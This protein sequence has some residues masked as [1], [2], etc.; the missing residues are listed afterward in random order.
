VPTMKILFFSSLFYP[1]IGGVE[2]HVME[3]SKLLIEKNHRISVVTENY[4]QELKSKENIKGIEIIRIPRIKKGKLKKFKI[5]KWLFENR[6]IISDADIIHCHDVFFWYMPFM[7]FYIKK[8]VYTTFHGYE[9]Y[10]LKLKDILMHKIAEK[11]SFGNIAVGSFIKKWYG[12][13]PTYITYGGVNKVKSDPPRWAG[14][15][16]I[17]S[18]KGAVFVGRL[19]K[20]TGIKT[21]VN[22]V[23]LIR[24]QMPFFKFG[25]IGDGKLRKEIKKNFKVLGFQRNP[26]KYFS[27]YNFAFASGYLSILE[28]MAEKRLIFADYDNPLKEDYLRMTPFSKFIV[29]SNSSS[30]LVSKIIFY[31]NNT[32]KQEQITEDA[33]EWVRKHTWKDVV[34]IYLK[35]W[36]L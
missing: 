14:K 17:K 16:K 26:E 33:Y 22:A 3:I 8:P 21:Y 31:L 9:N 10:P 30:E 6:K 7:F 27:K 12:T 32:K 4:S 18:L 23:K 29:I 13:K 2:K 36:K 1:H 5:W 11:L 20:Q 15:L 34:N 25:I 28:A 19:E 35:L 24:K